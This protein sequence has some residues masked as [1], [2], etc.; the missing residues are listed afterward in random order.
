MFLFCRICNKMPS[1]KFY[2]HLNSCHRIKLQDY[3]SDHPDQKIDYEKERREPWNKGLTEKDHPSIARYAQ[4]SRDY[5][6]QKEIRQKLSDRMKQRY[7]KGDILDKETRRIVVKKGSDAWVKKIKDSSLEEKKVILAAFTSAGNKAQAEKRSSLTPEDYE[8]LYPWAKGKAA[9]H[10][11]DF[12]KNQIIA[13]FGGKPRPKKRF[14]NKECFNNYLQKHPNYSISHTYRHIF[15]SEKMQTEYYLQSQLEYFLAVVLEESSQIKSWCT[16]PF[17]IPYLFDN[18]NR[19]YYLNFL[20]NGVD[21]VEV[22]SKYVFNM[23][24]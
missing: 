2:K 14:C 19:K 5:C 8:H 18:K 17:V 9:Y 23:S 22:K 24:P 12:C 10:D 21:L 7:A 4:A 16:T 1:E 13:W 15:H 3:F 6:N 20:V 11:C